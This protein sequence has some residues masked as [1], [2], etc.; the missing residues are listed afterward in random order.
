LGVVCQFAPHCALPAHEHVNAAQFVEPFLLLVESLLV[1][2]HGLQKTAIV[3]K[4]Q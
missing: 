4:R 3:N 2:S 1:V